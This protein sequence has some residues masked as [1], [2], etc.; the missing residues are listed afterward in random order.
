MYSCN[1]TCIQRGIMKS[2]VDGWR[3]FLELCRKAEAAGALNELFWLLLTSE[4]REDVK[5]RVLIV[6]EL[7]KGQKTQRQLAKDLKVSIAKITRG[8]NVLKETDEKLRR[9]FS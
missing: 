7:L 8:S 6:Q 4:E 2:E 9:L 3:L 5:T 1:I